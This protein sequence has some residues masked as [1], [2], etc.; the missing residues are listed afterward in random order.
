MFALLLTVIMSVG[1]S[2]VAQASVVLD[3]RVYGLKSVGTEE[4][5]GLLGITLGAEVNDETITAG[6]KRA[7]MKGVFEDI[8]V[9]EVPDNPGS[10][11]VKVREKDVI[12]DIDITGNRELRDSLILKLLGM[13]EGDYLLPEELEKKRVRL[14]E[15]L[16]YKGFPLAEVKFKVNRLKSPYMID[17]E[18]G[19]SE[20]APVLMKKIELVG[21]PKS[22]PRKSPSLDPGDRY[23]RYEVDAEITRI[24]DYYLKRGYIRPTIGQ[25][26]FE[27]GVLIIP[28]DPGQK[29]KIIV[30]GNSV[31]SDSDILEKL[32]FFHA[33]EISEGLVS[34]AV[35]NVMDLYYEKGH[36][37]AQVAPVTKVRDELTTFHLY[38]HEGEDVEL[39]SVQFE[40]STLPVDRLK[41]ILPI[42]EGDPYNPSLIRDSTQVI[43]EFYNALG[44][45]SVSVAGPQVEVINEDE[46]HVM[47]RIVEGEK[48]VIQRIFIE[49]G[50]HYTVSELEKEI[51][52]KDGSPYNEVDIADARRRIIALYK[53][54]GFVNCSVDVIRKAT[55]DHSYT[56]TFK[57]R[58]G[59]RFTFGKTIVSGNRSI[60][61]KVIARE[62]T[63]SEGDMF[64]PD[65]LA[66]T[67]R[68]LYKLGLFS[69]LQFT[70]IGAADRKVDILLNSIEEDAGV[71]EFGFGY[72]EYEKYRGFLDVS[73]RNV[74]GMNRVV[75]L[76]ADLD[77]LSNK[78]TLK[79]YEPRFF[80]Y[81]LPFTVSVSTEKRQEKN[82]DTDTTSYRIEKHSAIAS[83]ERNLSAAVKA[84]FDYEFSLVNTYDVQP[85]V[86][87]SRDD[88]GTIAISGVRPALTFD[89]R[90]NPFNPRHGVFAGI[91][92]KAA[93]SALLSETNFLKAMIHTSA[94]QS[95]SRW[96]VLAAS[97]RAGAAHSFDASPSIPLVER[98]FLGGRS[99]VRGY[100]QDELGPKGDNGTPTGG[101]A[102]LCGNLELRWMV[103]GG[104]SITTFMDAGNVWVEYTDASQEDLL[105]TAGAGL[106]Y[107]TPVG[108]LRVEYGHKLN[109]AR[110]ESDG[111]VHFSIGY[112][113]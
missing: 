29:L 39:K 48:Y 96:L 30:E 61:Y 102:Y 100:S 74:L 49:G 112:A 93:S 13:Q 87:L 4:L 57:L 56:I 65:A 54:S 12:D 73:Y 37:R 40:G 62:L 60:K 45:V 43:S 111:E 42:K 90:D 15:A 69:D 107:M 79:Y 68:A 75:S 19:I 59:E 25:Y 98:F 81:K 110:D 14:I 31:L 91:S 22:A 77:T 11:I 8:S 16:A 89:T 23:D 36:V 44:Y 70:V 5:L 34:E 108:P 95:L 17:L 103:Y 104:W 78:Y 51:N 21:I 58:E 84:G 88:T 2:G 106:Q 99:T 26:T 67:R 18:A 85:D 109:K 24:R 55:E 27:D 6:I 64:N 76:R 66:S 72:G 46:A 71:V 38:I 113:F 94:Y 97:V 50:S 47:F 82:I 105:Y 52:I 7:F 80:D 32:P 20:G 28:V 41:D 9:E 3:V 33:G 10:L 35:A 101:N 53:N 86:I 92:V 63:Y 83:I 1:A